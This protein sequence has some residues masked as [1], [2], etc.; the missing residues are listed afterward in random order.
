YLIQPAVD[1]LRRVVVPPDLAVVAK[2]ANA[3]RN[4]VVVR[5]DCAAISK[6]PEVL[7]RIEAEAPC[8]ADRAELSV[9][10]RCPHAL[11]RVF[12]DTDVMPASDFDNP[13]DIGRLA[14]EVHRQD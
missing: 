3:L 14:V 7:A 10:V 12:D 13:V 6:C 9:P 5:D 2:P 1:S 11:S 4:I 8:V